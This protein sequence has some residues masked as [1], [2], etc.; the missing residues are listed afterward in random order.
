MASHEATPHRAPDLPES[1]RSEAN[2]C[3]GTWK[4]TSQTPYPQRVRSPAET[5]ATEGNDPGTYRCERESRK[6]VPMRKAT[7]AETPVMRTKL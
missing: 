5:R 7:R 6:T 1:T 3:S 2:Y 4:H